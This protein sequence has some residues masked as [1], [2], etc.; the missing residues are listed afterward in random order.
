MYKLVN[1]QIKEEKKRKMEQ[2]IGF[3]RT[4]EAWEVIKTT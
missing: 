1:Q 4:T 3:R 2:Y